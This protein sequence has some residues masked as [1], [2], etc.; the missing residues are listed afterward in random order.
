LLI[1]IFV[2]GKIDVYQNLQIKEFY[3]FVFQLKVAIVP[4]L[5][6][7]RQKWFTQYCQRSAPEIALSDQRKSRYKVSYKEKPYQFSL[8][9]PPTI[10]GF[11]QQNCGSKGK[12][13]VRTA[14]T[15]PPGWREK[16]N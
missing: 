16:A 10:S 2:C 15:K 9:E 14:K 13:Q 8:R 12:C 4:F 1:Q 3:N 6:R 11:A 5:I 7:S